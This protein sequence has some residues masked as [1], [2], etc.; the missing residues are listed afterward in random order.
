MKPVANLPQQIF[1]SHHHLA[2]SG[3]VVGMERNLGRRL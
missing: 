1:V 3:K 2:D